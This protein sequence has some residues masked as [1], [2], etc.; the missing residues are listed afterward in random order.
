MSESYHEYLGYIG[1][2]FGYGFVML[3]SRCLLE[4]LLDT[5]SSTKP[6]V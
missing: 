2:G 3:V 4:H 5:I 1:H 6:M